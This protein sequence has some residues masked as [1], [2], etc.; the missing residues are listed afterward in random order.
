MSCVAR[1]QPV[2][3]KL[4]V[5]MAE[6]MQDTGVEPYADFSSS[7]DNCSFKGETKGGNP[8]WNPIEVYAV[9]KASL[10]ASESKQQQSLPMLESLAQIKYSSFV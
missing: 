3:N 10:S 4:A 8:Q 5:H 6:P 2:P 1:E 9:V 7:G